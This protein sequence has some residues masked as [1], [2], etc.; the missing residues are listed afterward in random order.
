HQSIKLILCQIDGDQP[1]YSMLRGELPLWRMGIADNL[2]LA[3]AVNTGVAAL[4]LHKVR[5]WTVSVP[6]VSV[7]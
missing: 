6:A 3:N 4:T 7:L 1:V 2:N 5:R